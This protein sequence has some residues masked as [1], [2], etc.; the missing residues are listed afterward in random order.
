MK[1]KD[2][3]YYSILSTYIFAMI[4]YL[5]DDVFDA[6]NQH[7]VD[8]IKDGDEYVD[9]YKQYEFLTKVP[10]SVRNFC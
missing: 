9:N 10:L 5:F 1:P 8:I 4:Y 2:K 7:F 3:I 6:N